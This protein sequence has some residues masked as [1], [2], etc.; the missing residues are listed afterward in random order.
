MMIIIEKNIKNPKNQIKK[1]KTN[2][3]KLLHINGNKSIL[4]Y[5]WR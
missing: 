1:H 5:N 2:Y 3:K 4:S